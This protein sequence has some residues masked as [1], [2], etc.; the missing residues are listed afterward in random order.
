MHPESALFA[1]IIHVLDIGLDRT[2]INATHTHYRTID[3]EDITAIYKPRQPYAHKGTYGSALMVGGTHGK[4]GAMVLSTKAALRAGAGLATAQVPECG[5]EVLQAAVPEAMCIT[6]GKNVL[7]AIIGWEKFTAIGVGPGMGTDAKSAEAL[8]EFIDTCKQPIVVDADALNI[9][10]S[11]HDLLPKL[12][13]GSILTPHPKEFSRLFGENTNSMIQV[14]NARIQAMRYNINI[15]LKGHHTAVITSE[16]E[17][18]YNTTGN[19][20]MATAGAGDVLTGIITGLLAQ[21]YAP[22][23][24]AMLGVYLHGLAGDLAVKELSQEALIAGDI[25]ERLGKAFLSLGEPAS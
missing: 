9:V 5:Y 15:V 16:G 17:C 2:F 7:E 18:W 10:A 20:G 8:A 4:I 25:I 23:E 6:N 13:M 19:P 12:P 21:G 1:G 3:T 11:H 24:A 22:H 14:D